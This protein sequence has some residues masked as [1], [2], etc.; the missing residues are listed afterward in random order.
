MGVNWRQRYQ[1]GSIRFDLL[2][3]DSHKNAEFEQEMTLLEE[4]VDRDREFTDVLNRQ[5]LRF[6]HKCMQ[7]N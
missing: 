3:V 2:E 5:K 6:L 7:Y 4:R 1:N